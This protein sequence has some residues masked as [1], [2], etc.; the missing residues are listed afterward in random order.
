M[1]GVEGLCDHM[2]T[3]ANAMLEWARSGAMEDPA[4]VLHDAP[5]ALQ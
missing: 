3:L 5:A 2:G 1:G 4:A